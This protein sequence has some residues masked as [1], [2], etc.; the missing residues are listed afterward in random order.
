[1]NPKIRILGAIAAHTLFWG[2]NL[3]FLS[4]L[5]FGMGPVMLFDTMYAA[6]LGLIP[7]SLASFIPMILVIPV[8]GMG[9]GGWKLRGDPGR[10]LSLFFGVQFPMMAM[11]M[12]RI[13]GL[14]ELVPSTTIL[15]GAF[16]F[17]AAALLRTLLSGF[18]ETRRTSQIVRLIGQTLYL[19]VGLWI[20]AFLGVYLMPFAIELGRGLFNYPT[21]IHSIPGLFA[22]LFFR[23]FGMFTMVV[24]LS[25]PVAMIGITLRAWQV[26]HR[27]SIPA[28][29]LRQSWA[30]SVSTFVGLTVAL[31]VT[32]HQPQRRAFAL[33]EAATDE[34]GRREAIDNEALIRRGLLNARLSSYRYLTVHS[35]DHIRYL[36]ERR[37]GQWSVGIASA[38]WNVAA[39]PVTYHPVDE[40][41]NADIR[42]SIALYQGFFDR[43][44]E[45]VERDEIQTAMRSTWNWQQAAA[46]L[47]DIGEQRVWLASQDI[48]VHPHGDHATVTLHDVY[49]NNTWANEEVLVSFSLPEDAVITGLWL[50]AN[51]DRS[52]AFTH[53]VAPRGAAQEVYERQVRR[54]VDPAL[55]E[56]VGPQQYRLRA[57]PV[58]PRAGDFD[59]LSSMADYGPTLHVWIQIEVWADA[60]GWPLPQRTEV[61]NL[62]WDGASTW[63][64]NG[65]LISDP[66]D[67]TPRHVLD[68]DAQVNPATAT[69]PPAGP[70][71][72]AVFID[73]S[74]SMSQVQG[75]LADAIHTLGTLEHDVTS[76]NYNP[77]IQP[78][79]W[80]NGRVQDE[81]TALDTLGY[82]AV[83]VIT[84]SSSYDTTG[85]RGDLQN[86]S[87]L[88]M[89]HLGGL[90]HAY[91]DVLLDNMTTTEGGIGTSVSEV[92]EKI[93]HGPTAH[94]TRPAQLDR[95]AGQLLA[96]QRSYKLIRDGGSLDEVHKLAV[97]N[98]LLTPWS[99]MIVLVNEA[100]LKM[101]EDASKAD[102]R[103]DREAI[104]DDSGFDNPLT[105][106]PEPHEWVLMMLAGLML[107]VRRRKGRVSGAKVISGGT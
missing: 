31:M 97:E 65:E 27:A 69:Q 10:L 107:E 11:A 24:F 70:Q 12:L 14:G 32:S 79:L 9:V 94:Q 5:L 80:G 67:W 29:G 44:M 36:Y 89:V 92:I 78:L 96:K 25:F 38:V 88:W 43:P 91:P 18:T 30:W 57:F 105:A 40:A 61:R 42:K 6:W 82:D 60:D 59:D 15:V 8:L 76:L 106:T 2:W 87:P 68:A 101:L 51:D 23:T 48:N 16:L 95:S 33:I 72:L 41:W 21:Y 34:A 53:V 17:G 3:L 84:D 64:V 99:S 71:N 85:D 7:W 93:E 49:R 74:R 81:L 103:F 73:T 83:L 35:D 26:V 22:E 19:W 62:F 45:R 47:L 90:P 100:Q 54:S 56:Q 39:W 50:G 77:E 13:F 28:V 98:D 86:K 58:L 75:A 4:I 66:G 46:G 104:D 52:T 37:L 1:M 20:C 63:S 55:L 102:D